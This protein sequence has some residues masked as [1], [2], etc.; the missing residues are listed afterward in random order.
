M[1][2]FLEFL[3]SKGIEYHITSGYTYIHSPDHAFTDYL[4]DNLKQFIENQNVLVDHTNDPQNNV[5]YD[6]TNFINHCENSPT[7]D[8]Y[9][10]DR[11]FCHLYELWYVRYQF[12]D[13][14]TFSTLASTINRLDTI[15]S[16]IPY[17]FE[18]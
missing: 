6:H 11:I 13:I 15:E 18:P 9:Y 14:T 16:T 10:L 8:E 12:I 2:E 4:S 17:Y 1:L 7:N 3:K 5:A